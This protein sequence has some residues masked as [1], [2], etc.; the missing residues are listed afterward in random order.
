[1]VRNGVALEQ[2]TPVPV[3]DA[4]RALH[5]DPGWPVAGIVGRLAPEKGQALAVEGWPRV[6]AK[7]PEARLLLVGDGEDA[8]TLSDQAEAL[9]L[10]DRVIFAGFQADP[11]P[12]FAACDVVLMPSRREGLGLAAIEAMALERPVLAANVG[13]LPEAVGDGETGLL[14][15]GDAAIFADAFLTLYADPARRAAMGRAGRARV[16]AHFN[17]ETQF[18]RLR[19]VLADAANAA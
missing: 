13:G 9:G 15:P 19:E 8:L 1:M 12:Y 6:L 2:Y 17:A 4:K 3:E 10:G 14:L 18:A 5:L 7:Q 16:A 11:L